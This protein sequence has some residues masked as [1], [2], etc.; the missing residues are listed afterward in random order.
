MIERKRIPYLLYIAVVLYLASLVDTWS[1]PLI[2]ASLYLT[3]MKNK[4][5]GGDLNMG[6]MVIRAY[7]E[8]DGNLLRGHPVR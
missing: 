5:K 8:E 3:W 7:V 2:A 6:I 4:G 1:E